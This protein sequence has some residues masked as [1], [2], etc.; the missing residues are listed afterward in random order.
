MYGDISVV[1]KQPPQTVNISYPRVGVTDVF[2]VDLCVISLCELTTFF[3]LWSW[4]GKFSKTRFVKWFHVCPLVGYPLDR[5]IS[6][7]G[8]VGARSK[9]SPLQGRAAPG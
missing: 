3:L 9:E 6:Q 7:D 1:M 2:F 5:Q 4:E 8:P